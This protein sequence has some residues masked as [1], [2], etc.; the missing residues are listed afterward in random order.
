MMVA[1]VSKRGL[2]TRCQRLVEAFPAETGRLRDLRHAARLGHV[3][4][5]LE[6]YAGVFV[7]G[8]ERKIFRNRFL[9][10]EIVS[11]L[12]WRVSDLC[13]SR[14]PWRFPW[15]FP[16]LWPSS[17]PAL[18]QFPRHALCP[19]DIA[20][21]A[22]LVAPPQSSTV[23]GGT[24]HARNR[25]GIPDAM[26]DTH[27]I[28]TDDAFAYRSSQYSRNCSREACDSRCSIRALAFSIFQAHSANRKRRMTE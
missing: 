20:A 16:W 28:A 7:A 15:R 14:L 4:K 18:L 27:W 1:I 11:D 26:V 6:Q 21:L 19:G 13:A 5:R 12:E 22:G 2:S 3:T 9:T 8:C 17:S 23:D 10:I 25:H 24:H